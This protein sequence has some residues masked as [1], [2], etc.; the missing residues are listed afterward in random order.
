VRIDKEFL[1]MNNHE[2]I[3]YIEFPAKDLKATKAFFESALAWQFKDFGTE[4]IA[5]RNEGVDGGFF[6]ANSAS[7]QA[8]GGALVIFFSENLIKT[9]EKIIAAG[10]KITQNIYEFPGGERF[11]FTEPSGNEFAVW[12]ELKIK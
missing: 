4:Y 5:F 6:K 11:N 12:G 7:T 10:G 1:I 9:Q 2:K 3:N 8:T